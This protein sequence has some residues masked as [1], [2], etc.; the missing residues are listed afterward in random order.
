MTTSLDIPLSPDTR[1]LL[2]ALVHAGHSAALVGGAVRDTLLGRVT[3]DIDI[4]TSATPG[5]V[6]AVC[7][8]AGWCTGVYAVGECHGTLGVVL[9][10]GSVVEVSMQ[11]GDTLAADAL[12]RDF[13]VNAIA[14][15]WPSR[16]I[17]DPTGGR[18]DLAA[19]VLRAPDDPAA[20]FGEDPLRVLRAARFVAQL[21]FEL[22][23]A[24]EAAA[25]EVAPGL[26]RVAAERVRDELSRLLLAP[27]AEVGLKAAQRISALAIVLPEVAKLGGVTQPSFH[28]LD[29]FSHTAQ[30]VANAPA[31]HVMRWAAL[32]H[33]VG[34]PIAVSICERLVMSKSDTRAI[35]HLVGEHMRL[36]DLDPDNERAVDRAV[37]RLDLWKPNVAEPELLVSAEDALELT[38]ADL[39]ATAHRERVAA[40]RERLTRALAA[41]RERGTRVRVTSPLTGREIITRLGLAEGPAVGAAVRAVKTAVAEGRIAANDRAAALE[42]ARAAAVRAREEL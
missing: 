22:D 24:T 18:A 1:A 10:D 19:R 34:T 26:S 31:V 21:G 14:V 13:T 27:G 42:I 16:A 40:V 30:T 12:L 17:L 41:S 20:R 3:R 29:A 37:R 36:A 5:E 32:L 28:D 39:G 6:R 23:P 25:S 7:E 4:A 8:G 9:A 11:R 33:D 38:L 15:E 35:A 2:D